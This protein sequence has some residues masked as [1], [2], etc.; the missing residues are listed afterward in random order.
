MGME[1]RLQRSAVPSL[2]LGCCA[3]FTCTVHLHFAIVC[4]HPWQHWPHALALAARLTRPTGWVIECKVNHL[5]ELT[6]PHGSADTHPSCVDSPQPCISLQR[7]L[8][9]AAA[10]VPCAQLLLPTACHSPIPPLAPPT[11]INDLQDSSGISRDE[12]A[13]ALMQVCV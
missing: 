13:A 3:A 6:M 11:T 4:R 8:H 2:L 7:H 9:A 1:V 5:S 10:T 12:M